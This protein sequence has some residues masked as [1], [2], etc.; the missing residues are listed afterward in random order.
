LKKLKQKK[1]K[2]GLTTSGDRDYVRAVFTKFPEFKNYFDRAVTSEDVERGKPNPDCYRKILEKLEI[3]AHEAVVLEDSMYGITAAKA[4][5]ISVIC[6]PNKYFPDAD[7]SGAD[8]IFPSL[9]DVD[10]AIL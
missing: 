3:S 7:Y 10:Q 4:A 5:G 1:M 2:I 8:K 9:L 6:V